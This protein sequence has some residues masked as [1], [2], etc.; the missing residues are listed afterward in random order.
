MARVKTNMNTLMRGYAGP[1]AFGLA[2]IICMPVLG[3][4]AFLLRGVFVAGFAAALVVAASI[5]LWHA[6]EPKL[7]PGC[8]LIVR[9]IVLGVAI[10]AGIPL[11]A[12]T[13][14]LAGG[15]TLAV[16]PVALVTLAILGVWQILGVSRHVFR[17]H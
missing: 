13:V 8:R 2:A 6:I 4:A 5:G 7:S 14:V 10:I 3:I 15:A 9:E 17:T 1:V 11:L 12:I 16:L